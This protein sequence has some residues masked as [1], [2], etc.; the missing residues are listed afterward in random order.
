MDQRQEPVTAATDEERAKARAQFRRK[1]AA[2]EAQMTPEK[3]ARVRAVLGLD[4]RA[5]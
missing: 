4:N 1:L 2:A 5:A 3:R